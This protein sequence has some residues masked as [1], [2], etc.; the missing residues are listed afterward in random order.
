MKY[1]KISNAGEIENAALYLLAST[2]RGQSGKIGQFGSGNKYQLCFF[3]RNHYDYKVFAG[4]REIEIST[5]PTQLRDQTVNVIYIDGKETSLTDQ[6]GPSWKLW[7]AIRE[8]YCNAIDEGG[9]RIEVVDEIVPVHGETQFYI[10]FNAS[11]QDFMDNFH[12]Y[13]ANDEDVIFSCSVGR[14]LRKR[15]DKRANIYR[16]G[17]KCYDASKDSVFD[18]DLYDIEINESR[19]IERDWQLY[20]GIWKLIQSCTD[21]EIIFQIFSKLLKDDVL[22]GETGFL[23]T[24]RNTF[25]QSEEFKRFLSERRIIPITY[26]SFLTVEELANYIVIPQKIYSEFKIQIKK[27]KVFDDVKSKGNVLYR[28]VIPSPMIEATLN[29]ALEFFKECDLEIPYDIQVAKFEDRKIYGTTD[30]NIIVLSDI[31]IERGIQE[32]I[33]S[34]IEEYIHIKY[35]C[36]DKTREMQSAIIREWIGYMKKKNTYLI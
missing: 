12:Q 21:E 36:F 24:L 14:I 1:L 19:T 26:A 7:Q 15:G 27:D 6:M 29:R 18:Y 2:K 8:I 10:G 16:K 11:I 32:T 5:V 9:Q 13:F 31:G 17:I 28:T 34:I 30:D 22:E 4:T 3:A 20:E 35:N 33:D 25:F 23:C